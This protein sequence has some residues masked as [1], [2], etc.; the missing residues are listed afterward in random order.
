MRV[1][2]KTK[3]FHIEFIVT[4]H[5]SVVSSL[6]TCLR[7]LEQSQSIPISDW[8]HKM[9]DGAKFWISYQQLAFLSSFGHR[10]LI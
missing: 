3:L 2:K 6:C 10:Q 5:N 7:Y 4:S 1:E 9:V 8:R